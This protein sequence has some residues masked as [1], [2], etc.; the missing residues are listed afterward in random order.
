MGAITLLDDDAG[1]RLWIGAALRKSGLD[2]EVVGATTR[3]VKQAQHFTRVA[4]HEAPK[5]R[6]KTEQW[7][8]A[9]R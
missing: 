2:A 1:A 4:W 9:T 3:C 5:M 6:S 8:L 7:A